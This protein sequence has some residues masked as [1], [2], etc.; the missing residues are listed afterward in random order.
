[1]RKKDGWR[2]CVCYGA[3]MKSAKAS[4]K[5][6]RWSSWGLEGEEGALSVS[7]ELRLDVEERWMVEHLEFGEWCGRA[8]E[9][10]LGAFMNMVMRLVSNW[11][12]DAGFRYVYELD[13]GRVGKVSVYFSNDVWSSMA[14]IKAEEAPS[15]SLLAQVALEYVRHRCLVDQVEPVE[16]VTAR[17]E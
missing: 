16:M 3:G 11:V 15:V 4:F 17:A 13:F 10:L 2:D 14:E 7:G 9:P 1:M 6:A 5:E 12:P 8:K